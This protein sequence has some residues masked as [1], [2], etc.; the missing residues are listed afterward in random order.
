MSAIPGDA[1]G[2]L[3]RGADQREHGVM[4]DDR[5]Y[6]CGAPAT[7]VDHVPPKVFF[8]EGD[9]H[10]RHLMT[11]PA[12]REHN[13]DRSLDDEYTA[14]LLVLCT[15]RR[16]RMPREFVDRMK[17]I[18]LR[19]NRGLLRRWMNR[20][21]EIDYGGR[22]T[23]AIEFERARVERVFLATARGMLFGLDGQRA[24][25]NLRIYYGQG[26]FGALSDE[27]FEAWKLLRWDVF[28]PLTNALLLSRTPVFGSNPATF[29]AA[30]RRLPWP[31]VRMVFYEE[32]EIWAM[33][34]MEE[35]SALPE[36]TE[37]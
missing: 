29:W 35:I 19:R 28:V 30:T 12:C 37:P 24:P 5:C 23:L 20:S 2:L 31:M 13:E 4:P 17:D 14:A 9:E 10:R 11:V 1:R 7:S 33:P 8:P 26:P 6:V 15:H 18:V 36:R 16:E 3:E 32:F 27:D 25:E 34:P 22:P 21:A